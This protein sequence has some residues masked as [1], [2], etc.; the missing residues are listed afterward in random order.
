VGFI[1]AGTY[2]WLGTIPITVN[3]FATAL[4][5]DT[6]GTAH[7][8]VC[9]TRFTGLENGVVG[10]C[11]SAASAGN[12]TVIGKIVLAEDTIGHEQVITSA[13]LTAWNNL[14]PMKQDVIFHSTQSPLPQTLPEARQSSI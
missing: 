5:S 8:I 11:H 3:L 13:L 6:P 7:E 4:V 14:K 1:F 9:L 12:E 2:M 10:G